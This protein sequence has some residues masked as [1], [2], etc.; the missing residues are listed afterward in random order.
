M[1]CF[2]WKSSFL[3]DPAFASREISGIYYLIR[4]QLD[5]VVIGFF[6]CWSWAGRG[7]LLARLRPAEPLCLLGAAP[8][9]PGHDRPLRRGSCVQPQLHSGHGCCCLR[10]FLGVAV[11]T[12]AE[13]GSG[14]SFSF[15]WD[16]AS[17]SFSAGLALPSYS[18]PGIFKKLDIN[19]R[20]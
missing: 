11:S 19:Q 9:T 16:L 18:L 4:T 3:R 10:P 2:G 20:M 8:R 12:R 15:L 17:S 1:E 5:P 13:P 7:D 14:D 6:S